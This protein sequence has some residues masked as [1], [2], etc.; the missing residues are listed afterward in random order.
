MWN[1]AMDL[2]RVV[3]METSLKADGS[4]QCHSAYMLLSLVDAGLSQERGS[5]STWAHILLKR[6]L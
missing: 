6:Y 5:Y 4:L 3:D 2:R 1:S